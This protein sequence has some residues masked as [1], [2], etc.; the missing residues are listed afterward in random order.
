M[1]IPL[2]IVSLLSASCG[3]ETPEPPTVP[4]FPSFGELPPSCGGKDNLQPPACYDDTLFE[5]SQDYPT[6]EPDSDIDDILKIAYDEDDAWLDYMDALRAYI[7]EGNLEVDFVVQ[8][9]AVR[10]WYHMPWQH[11]GKAAREAVHGL[12]RE[13]TSEVGQL[14]PEQTETFDTY[15]I[16][17]YN[18][19]GGYTIGQ[20]WADNEDPR[21]E[22][23]RFAPGTVVAKLLFTEADENQVPYLTNPIT[24]DAWAY[25]DYPKPKRVLRPLQL[26]QMD[27]MVRDPRHEETGGWVFATYIYNGTLTD[28]EP[29]NRLRPLGLQWGDDPEVIASSAS[30]AVNP[31]PT[32]TKINPN[33]A[34]TRINA[35][36]T[37]SG[38]IP[39]Q[40][41]GWDGRLAGAVD[42]FASSCQSCHGTAEWPVVTALNPSFTTF[43]PN[44]DKKGLTPEEVVTLY[45]ARMGADKWMNWF[46]NRPWGEAWDPELAVDLDFSLQ[47]Q[48]S[49]RNFY[50][51]RAE[52]LRG[53]FIIDGYPNGVNNT[54][55][56][57]S[58]LQDRGNEY[59]AP[60]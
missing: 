29:W 5:L 51:S 31:T 24:W 33:L 38:A 20:V 21:P 23:A 58:D 52:Q 57:P 37:D 44:E 26:I 47:M 3:P 41:L 6:S 22:A 50:A 54:G 39:P 7:F 59:Q 11:W 40:H 55:F 17:F 15:A 60:D 28:P 8:E 42:N 9:N 1:L 30:G 4:R 19:P 46:Q 43:V 13:A 34:E 27:V 25:E 14:A 45:Y 18:A 12:T 2:A 48:I 35:A 53:I 36:E 32:E 16:G 49:I 10:T 56:D